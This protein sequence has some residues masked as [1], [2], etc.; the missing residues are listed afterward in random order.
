LLLLSPLFIN[1][2][3]PKPLF[4]SFSSFSLDVSLTKFLPIYFAFDY[5]NPFESF[6]NPAVF[7]NGFIF[8][9]L[10]EFYRRI[11]SFLFEPGRVL[12]SGKND[13][14]DFINESVDFINESVDLYIVYIAFSVGFTYYDFFFAN[15]D[16]SN[17]PPVC[18]YF[19]A[20]L[21]SIYLSL[22]YSCY[23]MYFLRFYYALLC[24][25][26]ILSSYYCSFLNLYASKRFFSYS[27]LLF[28]SYSFAFLS[29]KFFSVY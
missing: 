10:S 4:P 26:F 20:L 16:K 6:V 7:C 28:L 23:F 2:F 15:L 21:S 24:V 1:G 29:A 13:S 9:A 17:P 3:T 22:I 18:N 12:M 14:D 8:L 11:F 27:A 19:L 5:K 25:Y